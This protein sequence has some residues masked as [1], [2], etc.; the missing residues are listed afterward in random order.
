MKLRLLS[1]ALAAFLF[2]SCSNG[3]Y[4]EDEIRTNALGY[5]QAV[6][7]YHFDE[8][9]PYCTLVTRE[10]TLATFKFLLD[11]SDTAYVNSNRPSVFTIHK[12]RQIDD[13]TA[14]VYYHKSTPIKEMDDSLRVVYEE[15]HWLADFRLK[16]IPYVNEMQK[17]RKSVSE[18]PRDYT[19]AHPADSMKREMLTAPLTSHEGKR[20]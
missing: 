18:L 1:L 2:V 6:G 10:K 3:V 13:T 9:I 17:G 15:G 5:L 14:R 7:D 20:Q 8:A 19:V 11:H 4:N 16:S 12:I